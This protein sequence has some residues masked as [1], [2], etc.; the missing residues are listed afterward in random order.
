M[1]ILISNGLPSADFTDFFQISLL[2]PVLAE[3]WFLKTGLLPY[4]T[5]KRMRFLIEVGAQ[6]CSPNFDKPSL[7]AMVDL[8]LTEFTAC[9]TLE[10]GTFNL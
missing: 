5:A 8:C 3:I 1:R 10:T 2:P 7:L 6:N 4:S 9:P